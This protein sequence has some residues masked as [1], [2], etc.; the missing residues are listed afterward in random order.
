MAE[1]RLRIAVFSGP[2]ATVQ[3]SEPLVTGNKA[4]EK[5]GLP[6]RANADG[7]PLRFDALRPQRLAAPAKVYVQQFSAHPLE[8][9]AADL[10]GAPDGY[11]DAKGAFH[12]ARSSPEDVPVY[13]ITLRP[14][15][16]LYLLP[17]MARQAD[18]KP[19]DDQTA[20]PMAPAAKTRQTFYPDASRIFEE[21]DRFGLGE[22]GFANLLSS[23]ADF[24]F[25]RAAPSGGYQKGLPAALRTDAGQGDIPAETWGKDFWPYRPPHLRADPPR[26]RL[27]FVTNLVQ[28]TMASG[29]YGGAIWLEGSP[30]VEESIYWLNLL[31]ETD[32]PLCGNSSQRPHGA[33][34]N[35]GDRNVVDSVDYIVSGIWKGPDGKDSVGAVA[36]LDEMIFH[37]REVQKA[38]A[39]PGGYV[40][41]G[42]HGGIVGSIGQPG[43]PVLTFRPARLH[44]HTSAVRLTVLPA[45][46]SGVRKNGEK[47]S[48]MSV[49]VK[50][51][52]GRLLAGAIPQVS[53]HKSGRY[54]PENEG[55]GPATEAD[56]LARIERNLAT[57]PLSGFIG[58]G[59]APFGSLTRPMDAALELAVF[60]GMP[61]VKVGRGNAEGM[62]PIVPGVFIS[63]MNLTATKAR[64]LL[65][66]SLLKL[67]AIPPAMD[68]SKPTEAE[69]EA[70][71]KKIAEYQE[72]FSTH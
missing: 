71:K 72:I 4:R 46:V 12:V 70:A 29:K 60:S 25:F 36:V 15:D 28:E 9:D 34:S 39:R 47:I 33:L 19:W 37:S 40:A 44:T 58:E 66:A 8:R 52:Q 22:D 56:I 57:A 17:Y 31:I 69:R 1:K 59:A 65:M 63:G 23:K 67:G 7:S 43:P 48:V 16:G 42:G 55:T 26:A 11:L 30:N 32:V 24:D 13:E 41:T 5:Y 2:T 27:A 18:G 51:A 53:F 50:D 10:Y 68:P 3:N 14:E 20:F 45:K 6:P 21:I 62:V 38:D 49:D 64:L 61:V 35:D 54:S